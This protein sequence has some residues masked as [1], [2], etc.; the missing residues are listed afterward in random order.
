MAAAEMVE[1]SATAV[2]AE[3]GIDRS[4]SASRELRVRT[5]LA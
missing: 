3:L 4:P 5:V 2:E 1:D